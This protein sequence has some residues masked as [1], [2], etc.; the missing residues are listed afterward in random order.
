MH[1][2]HHQITDKISDRVSNPM[3]R[4]LVQ[5]WHDHK[6]VDDTL[7]PVTAF[8]ADDIDWCWDN[9]MLLQ[10]MPDDDLRYIHYGDAIADAAGFNLKGKCVS[11]FRSPVGHFF[12]E[13]YSLCLANR[14]P[15][16][17]IHRAD[18]AP[19]VQSWERLM[20]PLVD[21]QEQL[22]ILAFNQPLEFRFDLLDSI[23]R[24][25]MDGIIHLQAERDASYHII[26]FVITVLNP[27]A[28]RMA[29]L[30]AAKLIDHRLS[31]LPANNLL[32]AV[33]PACRQVLDAGLSA[34]V[35]LADPRPGRYAVFTVN[36]V[37]TGDG[38]T[39]TLTNISSHKRQ[40]QELRQALTALEVQMS[41]RKNLQ[42]ELTRMATT[43]PLTGALNRRELMQSS[44]REV[45]AARRYGRSLSLLIADIDFFKK[46]NDTY[47][48]GVGDIAIC[49]VADI[50]Q[51]ALRETD[52]V[53]R[54]GGEEYVILMPETSGERAAETADRLR[55]AIA[56]ATIPADDGSFSI[57]AS[58]GVTEW[59][60]EDESIEVTLARADSALYDAKQA[61]RNRVELRMPD[62]QLAAI[63][64]EAGMSAD[65]QPSGGRQSTIRH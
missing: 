43:D 30:P 20:L 45:A 53:A 18:L 44:K 61:G 58:F 7:P 26:D 3:V 4:R 24:A 23:L 19:T 21:D 29:A 57:T 64:D 13:K 25:S 39:V 56:A 62:T 33:E 54:I 32:H 49:T 27:A 48:H 50:C 5:R 10:Q 14:S 47:G 8:A 35:E 36:A 16:Y 59:S 65:R 60:P 40:E 46:V 34:A 9:V 12:R 37:R 28:E 42:D 52:L 22:H 11:H 51:Q 38:V 6:P 1:L 41:E 17:T 31:E 63:G 2:Y 15:L 55:K